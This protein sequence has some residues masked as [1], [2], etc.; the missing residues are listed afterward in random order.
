MPNFIDLTGHKYNKWFVIKRGPNDK[1]GWAQWYCKCD[2]GDIHLVPRSSLRSGH[3]KGCKKCQK[4]DYTNSK[5]ALTKHGMSRTNIYSIWC[6][7]K[8]RCYNKKDK[9]YKWYGA[10]GIK[11]CNEWRNDFIQFFKDMG[12]KPINKSLDRIDTTKDYS[13]NNCKWSTQSE[14]VSNQRRSLKKGQTINNWKIIKR[15]W[16][17]ATAQCI[18]CQRIVNRRVSHL[19]QPSRSCPCYKS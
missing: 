12:Y 2:C 6:H 8:D 16:D 17:R 9:S 19:K 13:K 1:G 10:K 14:Q 7:M 15:E 5:K 11:V 18:K 4:I 3:S